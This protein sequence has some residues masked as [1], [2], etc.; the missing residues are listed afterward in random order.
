MS[1]T[2]PTFV[3]RSIK[4]H[5]ER[6]EKPYRYESIPIKFK[7]VRRVCKWEYD[8]EIEKWTRCHHPNQK[9]HTIKIPIEFKKKRFYNTPPFGSLPK[10]NNTGLFSKII[11]KKNKNKFEVVK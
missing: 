7:K 6:F 4:K 2:V 8:E 3:S 9:R 11:K 10:I 5:I 1:K